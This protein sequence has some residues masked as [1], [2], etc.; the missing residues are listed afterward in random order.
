MPYEKDGRIARILLNRLEVMNAIDLE[1][2]QAIE[3]AVQCADA[4]P[5]VHVVVLSGAG[6]EFCAGYD[7][8]FFAETEGPNRCVQ[9]MP[10][11]AML[12]CRF[13]WANTQPFMFL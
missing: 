2:P 13:I 8:K 4:D 12:D 7:L 11:R 6:S 1:M 5:D 3:E 9:D 10:W